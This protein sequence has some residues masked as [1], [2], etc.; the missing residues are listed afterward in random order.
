MNNFVIDETLNNI[1]RDIKRS[2]IRESLCYQYYEDEFDC[3]NNCNFEDI[4]WC[5]NADDFE[6][7]ATKV[8]LF[9]DKED[10][11]VFKIPIYGEY[12]A[13]EGTINSYTDANIYLRGTDIP[14][15][16]YC[17]REAY[18]TKMAQKVQVD[19]MIAKTFFLTEVNGVPIYISEKAESFLYGDISKTTPISRETEDIV[20]QMFSSY[21]DE[22][23]SIG[24]GHNTPLLEIFIEQYGEQKGWDLL[25]FLVDYSINDI[26]YSN[27]GVTKD[28]KLK[29]IDYSGYYG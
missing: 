20:E 3:D 19:D 15:N 8:V 1:I 11:Y 27:V 14:N 26:H 9:Y 18:L 6:F 28:G 13:N 5:C 16:N 2:N 22:L 10:R 12:I 4:S 25:S 21:P 23:D 7:G 24:F 29:L 17:A